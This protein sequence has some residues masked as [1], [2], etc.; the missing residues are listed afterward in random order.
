MIPYVLPQNIL[1]VDDDPLVR[2]MLFHI[3]VKQGHHVLS[4]ANG[5]EALDLWKHFQG[6]FD[7]LI[8]D[9]LMP[10]MNG[11]ELADRI[12]ALD[13]GVKVLFI[14]GYS[15]EIIFPQEALG[16]GRAFLQKPFTLDRLANRIR[17]LL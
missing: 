5:E 1:V 11:R 3:L 10:Q 17:E 6:S 12:A 16:P 7:L 2:R 8:T 13:P 15:D 4:A 14:S 9:V